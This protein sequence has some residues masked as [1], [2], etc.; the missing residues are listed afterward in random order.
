MLCCRTSWRYSSTVS[1]LLFVTTNISSNNLAESKPACRLKKHRLWWKSAKE[2]ESEQ[3]ETYSETIENLETGKCTNSDLHY[4]SSQ[5]AKEEELYRARRQYCEQ[6]CVWQSGMKSNLVWKAIRYSVIPAY[7]LLLFCFA[8]VSALISE[9]DN[10]INMK[11]SISG[12]LANRSK[13]I[14]SASVS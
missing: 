10:Y 6:S 11:V 1:C 2:K 9:I 4:V 12:H 3:N 13:W 5:P 14:N 7:I 8:N